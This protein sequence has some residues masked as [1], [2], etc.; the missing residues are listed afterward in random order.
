L[1]KLLIITG[2][3][4]H[5]GILAAQEPDVQVRDNLNGLTFPDFAER[6]ESSS[7][8]HFYF[9]PGWLD[10][11]IIEYPVHLTSL[12]EILRHTLESRNIFFFTD[13]EGNIILTRG[14]S[15]TTGLV[16]GFFEMP[17][18]FDQGTGHLQ[19]LAG[20]P[21]TDKTVEQVADQNSVVYIGQASQGNGTGAVIVSGYITDSETGEPITGA[22]VYVEDLE[23]G[24]V[25]DL[26]GYYVISVPRGK[27]I[28]SFNFLGKK[29]IRQY[30]HLY[31]DGNMNVE[32]SEKITQLKGV[33]IVA[34]R[35]RNVA[36][37]QI[38]LSKID[39][40]SIRELPAVMGEADIIRAA[41]LLPGVQTVGEGASG[42][43]VRGGST[44][45][46]LILINN[47]PVFNS[48]HLFGFF[49]VFNP[50]II[51][52]LKLYKS[53]I[54]ASY[55]GRISSVFDIITKTGNKKKISVNGGISPVTGRLMIEGPLIKDKA[56]FIIGCRTTY[57]DWILSRIESPSLKNSDAS[58]YDLNARISYDINKNNSIDVTGYVSHDFLMLHSDTTYNYNNRNATISYKH[59]FSEKLIGSF[60]GIYSYYEYGIASR[61]NP[62]TAF[63]MIYD[64]EDMEVKSD[65]TWFLRYDHKIN[66]GAGSVW[67]LLNPGDLYP[68][69]EESVI[70]PVRL[71]YE[72]GMEHSIYISDEYTINQKLSMYAGFRF[73]SFLYMGPKTVYSYYEQLPKETYNISDTAVYGNG[74]LIQPY[75]GPEFRF[76][77]RYKTGINSSLKISY[78]RMRQYL[79]MLS[80]TTAISPTDT[81]KLSNPYIRPQVG[82]QVAIGMY[83]DFYKGSV[84]TSA[85]IYYKNISNI[86][87]YKGGAELLLNKT[88]ETDLVNGTGKAYGLEM[89]LRKKSGRLNGWIGYT[90]SRTWIRASS[91]FPEENINDG[92]YFPAN[93]DKPHDLT[94]AGNY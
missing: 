32:M 87:E 15:V 2:L 40:K 90:Y 34:D 27:H 75:F 6:V 93:Y 50:D 61:Q 22:V 59:L 31:S 71:E 65:F 77:V 73:S 70:A 12:S 8:V 10:S 33:E 13:P 78:N 43:N 84:E 69:G 86:I 62:A 51:S 42:F 28:L 47:A 60:S 54:P 45:Q 26:D 4:F 85:E 38:G 57:S 88:I 29:E 52:E 64:I 91:I 67:Y 1:R 55:G 19:P 81:W 20:E 46:N 53:G 37:M 68:T 21:V 49:S 58:F 80:N 17:E 41:L 30:I 92:E 11:V 25:S 76:S 63:E 94:M 36:G 44:D 66:F 72:R 89:M 56:S 82:D 9:N 7:P 3:I 35:E 74:S 48:S 24:V 16:P 14:A 39:I 79:H 18:Q 23:I 5:L 83:Y